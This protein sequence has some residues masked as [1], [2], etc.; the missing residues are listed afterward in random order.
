MTAASDKAYEMAQERWRYVFEELTR[1]EQKWSS[2]AIDDDTDTDTIPPDDLSETCAAE[3]SCFEPPSKDILRAMSKEN[4]Y[5]KFLR[6]VETGEELN[7]EYNDW[8]SVEDDASQV[9]ENDSATDEQH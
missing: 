9:E 6:R 8:E 3:S 2:P 4:V 7:V 5:Y 1:L